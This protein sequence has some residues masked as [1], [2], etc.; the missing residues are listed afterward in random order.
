MLILG[1]TPILASASSNQQIRI[2]Y[3]NVN[4][5]LQWAYNPRSQFTYG[6]GGIKGKSQRREVREGKVSTIFLCGVGNC[7]ESSDFRLDSS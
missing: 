2:L 5:G 3:Q 4:L 1:D 7:T 6:Y